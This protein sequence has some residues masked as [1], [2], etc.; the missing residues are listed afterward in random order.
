MYRWNRL[1]IPGLIFITATL[2]VFQSLQTSTSEEALASNLQNTNQPVIDV[3]SLF[4]IALLILLIVI[5]V[6]R[7]KVFQVTVGSILGLSSYVF[8]FSTSEWWS[9]NNMLVCS[10]S[11]IIPSRNSRFDRGKN[12]TVHSP[13]VTHLQFKVMPK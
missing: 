9:C 11:Q 5:F 10:L 12:Q 6:K 7:K 13:L 4:S 3:N 2:F 1:H 8:W